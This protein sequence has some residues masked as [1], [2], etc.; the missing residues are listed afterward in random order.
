MFKLIRKKYLKMFYN[1]YLK[2]NATELSHN[3][4]TPC[5]ILKTSMFCG[6]SFINHPT[7]L[8]IPIQLI[9]GNDI[10]EYSY[11]HMDNAVLKS[12]RK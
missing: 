6:Y 7:D 10:F 11:F 12:F 4:A 3:S 9:K 5:V 8:W 1:Y 2:R